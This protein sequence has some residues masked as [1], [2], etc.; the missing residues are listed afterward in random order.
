MRYLFS[1]IY[2]F[3]EFFFISTHPCTSC[4]FIC[5]IFNPLL[6]AI[7]AC[8]YH[9]QLHAFFSL[10]TALFARFVRSFPVS[11]YC[12][13]DH[14]LFASAG[15]SVIL[16]EGAIAVHVGV[17]HA[18][19]IRGWTGSYPEVPNW[20]MGVGFVSVSFFDAVSSVGDSFVGVA[21]I[22]DVASVAMGTEERLL[23]SKLGVQVWSRTCFH[24]IFSTTVQK[25]QSIAVLT[26]R[27]RPI[28]QWWRN[29]LH[30]ACE[31]ASIETA[32]PQFFRRAFAVRTASWRRAEDRLVSRHIRWR[33]RAGIYGVWI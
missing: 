19:Q 13:S 16:K 25:N 18:A 26:R 11:G 7:S 30:Q 27:R 28:N 12:A 3:L 23:P 15:M 5:M 4:C 9:V 8:I 6:A 10:F 1:T 2:N 29:H 17:E 33:G 31:L 21:Q 14:A 24:W 22:E 32:A 20:S